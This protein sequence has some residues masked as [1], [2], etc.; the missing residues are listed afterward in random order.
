M[1][2]AQDTA[3]ALPDEFD[4]STAL[5]ATALL[6]FGVGDVATT[7]VG[8]KQSGI[9]EGNPAARGVLD[10]GGTPAM[11]VVKVAV[12]LAAYAAYN[13]APEDHRIGIPMGL[14]L[15]GVAVVYHNLATIQEAVNA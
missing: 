8:L 6:S 4:P 1:S 10:A 14:A 7:H 2:V 11:I 12:F 15:L 3:D 13:Q 5:W 9:H